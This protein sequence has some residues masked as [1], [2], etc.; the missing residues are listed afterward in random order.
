[1]SSIPVYINEF[2]FVEPLSFF[3][4]A[5]VSEKWGCKCP[6]WSLR[7]LHPPI[8]GIMKFLRN[9]WNYENFE[10]FWKSWEI[11]EILEILKILNFEYFEGLRNFKIWLW[12]ILEITR[13]L[14]NIKNPVEIS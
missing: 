2:I 5:R 1:M 10:K 9:F 13:I 6:Y 3:C 11:L 8:F 12:V 4:V 7:H 14:R